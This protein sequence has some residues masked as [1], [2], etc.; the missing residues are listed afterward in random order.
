MKNLSG[1]NK[2]WSPGPDFAIIKLVL[3]DQVKNLD[4]LDHHKLLIMV[5]PE[6]FGP[7][8]VI[9]VLVIMGVI[10]SSGVHRMQHVVTGMTTH[11]LAWQRINCSRMHA[12][13]IQ[14]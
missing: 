5:C 4:H 12:G 10:S 7:C 1:P 9:V 8:S 11:R 14:K 2:Y 3:E 6:L 13:R